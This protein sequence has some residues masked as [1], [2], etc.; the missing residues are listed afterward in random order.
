[1]RAFDFAPLSRSTIGFDRLFEMLNADRAEADQAYPPTDIIR[2]GEDTFCICLALAGFAALDLTITAQQNLLTVAGR[3]SETARPE[4]LYQGI[5][6][7]AFE[8][9]FD[10]AD[11][12]EVDGASFE[13]GMLQ[14]VL[15]RKLPEAQKPRRI[16]IG[17]ESFPK[18]VEG[19]R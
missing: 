11:Y 8:R 5:P 12:V 16:P 15:R 13:N 3:K 17:G 1:M 14:I 6:A 4:Y 19:G 9:R 7:R 10:L 2:T 18:V